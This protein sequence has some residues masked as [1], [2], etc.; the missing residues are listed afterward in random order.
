MKLNFYI[1]PNWA[2][3]NKADT[4]AL[5]ETFALLDIEDQW[6]RLSADDQRALLGFAPFG[7]QE[8]MVCETGDIKIRRS[9]CFGM[10]SETCEYRPALIKA[11]V[12]AK[13][14]LSPGTFGPGYL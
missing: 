4:L 6:V 10:D 9:S 7:K 3:P 13:K 5:Y 14:K 1:I 11:A 12:A 2:I 8:I